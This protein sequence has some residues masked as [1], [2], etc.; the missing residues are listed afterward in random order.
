MTEQT[1]P[2][3][4]RS[5]TNDKCEKFLTLPAVAQILGVPCFSVRRAAKRGIFPSYHFGANRKLVR[6]SE[7]ISAVEQLSGGTQP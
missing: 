3:I 6:L 5:E 1:I 2:T 7:V 4:S